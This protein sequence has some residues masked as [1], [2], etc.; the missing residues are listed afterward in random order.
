[1]RP[2]NRYLNAAGN[3]PS[4][5]EATWPHYALIRKLGVK[6][7]ASK[8][9]EAE[10][11]RRALLSQRTAMLTGGLATLPTVRT[12]ATASPGVTPSGMVAFIW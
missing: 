9:I 8:S 10:R 4:S 12:T 3:R 2:S 11:Q 6:G 1:M 7:N 5:A